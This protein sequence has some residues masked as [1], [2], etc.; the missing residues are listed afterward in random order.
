[1]K[2]SIDNRRCGSSRVDRSAARPRSSRARR[3]CSPAK[4]GS[5]AP[6]PFPGPHARAR[7]T[8]RPARRCAPSRPPTRRA[9]AASW[10][11]SASG[12]EGNQV[13]P[14][15]IFQRC[16]ELPDLRAQ[17]QFQP[18]FRL[19]V[20]IARLHPRIQIQRLAGKSA[21]ACARRRRCETAAFIPAIAVECIQVALEFVQPIGQPRRRRAIHQPRQALR[22]WY[23]YGLYGSRKGRHRSRRSRLPQPR[24]HG[25]QVIARSVRTRSAP[26]SLR[27]TA[28][29]AR[30]TPRAQS[31][32]TCAPAPGPMCPPE[33]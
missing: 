22:C 10:R 11:T 19:C 28:T 8:P 5:A 33:S 31:A 18:R 32:H 9:A 3:H 29:S 4:P 2:R 30:P 6:R 27:H 17:F 23:Q 21:P 14:Q 24:R 25:P 26:G 16:L 1:M 13:Q 20:Q 12:R 15:Q 7:Q